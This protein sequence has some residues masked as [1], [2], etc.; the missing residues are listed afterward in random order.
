MQTIQAIY[1][2]GVFTPEKPVE[3]PAGSRVIVLVESTAKEVAHLRDED[4][5]FLDQ[6]AQQRAEV[7]RRLAE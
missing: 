7:F 2:N 4:R 1:N 5:T 3:L 6:L